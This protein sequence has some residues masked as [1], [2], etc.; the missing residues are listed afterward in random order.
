MLGLRSGM[1]KNCSIFPALSSSI[2][3]SRRYI[4][5]NKELCCKRFCTISLK[6][7]VISYAKTILQLRSKKLISRGLF[8]A[9]T[10]F[11][12]VAISVKK[13]RPYLMKSIDEIYWYNL[14]CCFLVQIKV[15]TG[16]LN[17][18]LVCLRSARLYSLGYNYQLLS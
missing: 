12:N 5:S 15:M 8:L 4:L 16:I 14:A 11:A 9:V 6:N 2:S 18:R 1:T 13:T 3:D 10:F 17:E 7:P